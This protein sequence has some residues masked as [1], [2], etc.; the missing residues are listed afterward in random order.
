MDIAERNE[1]REMLVIANELNAVN[2]ELSAAIAAEFEG[3]FQE[4]VSIIKDVGKNLPG[5]DYVDADEKHG[6]E[7]GFARNAKILSMYVLKCFGQDFSLFINL[8]GDLLDELDEKD[9]EIA[10]M[11][12]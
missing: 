10:W 1:L 7:D 5:F 4:F 11:N 6:F 12:G 9:A 3:I 2:L 8:V